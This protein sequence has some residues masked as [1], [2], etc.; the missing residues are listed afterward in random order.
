MNRRPIAFRELL[1]RLLP[2]EQLSPAERTRVQRALDS[3]AEPQIEQAGLM[4]LHSLEQIGA[5]RRLPAP[6]DDHSGTLRFQTAA[7]LDVITVELP[8]TIRRDGIEVHSRV[9]LLSQAQTGLEQV[10]RLMRLDDP[11]VFSDPRRGN[12]RAGLISVLDETGRELMGAASVR[13]LPHHAEDG[14]AEMSPFDAALALRARS[15]ARIVLGCPDTDLAPSLATEGR[16][17]GARSLALAG[18]FSENGDPLGHLEAVGTEP[19]AFAA[20]ELALLALLADSTALAWQRSARIE[21]L[22][23]IDPMTGAFNRSYFDRQV[24]NE[25]AR[26][27]REH[28]SF[29]LCIADIDNFKMFNTRYGYEAGNR[30]LEHVASTLQTGV[31]PFDTVA[32][33]GGEE[34]A[35]FLPSAD[36]EGAAIV[37]ERLREAFEDHIILAPDGRRLPVT[38]SFGVAAYPDEQGAEQLLAAGDAALYAAK[39]SGKNRVL[40][41]G[42]LVGRP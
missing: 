25:M 41:A 30:V 24:L 38:A 34:F 18:V 20:S 28:T 21:N 27:A 32:R 23:F 40:T 15:D 37:A 26:S 19:A 13:F 9:A 11:M 42:A 36:A 31:R 7:A 33:W 10:R 3:G 5:I 1:E 16:R 6:A 2:V 14:V 8:R 29:S 22:V 35:I 17:R 12:A 39:R 4:A